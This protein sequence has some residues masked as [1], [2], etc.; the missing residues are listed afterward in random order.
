MYEQHFGL[1]VKPFSLSPDPRFL[2]FSKRHAQAYSML[3]YGVAEQVGF[4]LITGEVGSGKTTLLRKLVAQLDDSANIAVL[5]NTHRGMD[6]IVPSV[7]DAFGAPLESL[8]DQEA[9]YY[10]LFTD[11]LSAEYAKGRRSVLVIDEAQNLSVSALEQLRLLS[12]INV[13]GHLMLQT[14]LIGQPELRSTLNKPELRQFAQRISVDFFLPRLS[15][16]ESVRYIEHRI[17]VAGGSPDL[18]D[19]DAKKALAF[20]AHGLPRMINNL[21]DMALVYAFGEQALRVTKTTVLDVYKDKRRGGI[22]PMRAVKQTV[23]S[24]EKP[25]E[26]VSG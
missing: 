5:S 19:E 17:N 23:R 13:D 3:E 15:M 11:F 4:A 26:R 20:I 24:P 12:N 18:F 21:A 10:R 7:L 22:L 9:L 16:E 8:P 14:I 2:F 6:Q 1:Q 25:L